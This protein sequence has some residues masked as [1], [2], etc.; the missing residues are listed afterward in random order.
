MIGEEKLN[1]FIENTKFI[2]EESKDTKKKIIEWVEKKYPNDFVYELTNY[3]NP[4]PGTDAKA[5]AVI[6][7][8]AGMELINENNAARNKTNN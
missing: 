8:L 6:I 7:A 5:D 4:K 2:E 3:G 1:I